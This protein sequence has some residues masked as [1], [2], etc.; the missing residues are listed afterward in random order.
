MTAG[1]FRWCLV[2][3]LK[4]FLHGL[5]L[6]GGQRAT[7]GLKMGD[8]F[9]DHFTQLCVHFLRII[10]VNPRDM[11]GAFTNVRPILLTPFHPLM[12]LVA[13]LHS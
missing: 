9:F 13:L 7:F 12:I 11:I 4:D 8:H 5:H 3:L 10:P 6:W 2:W 1:R